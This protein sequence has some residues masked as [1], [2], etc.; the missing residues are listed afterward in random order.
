MATC[1]NISRLLN[2]FQVLNGLSRPTTRLWRYAPGKDAPHV[3]S[4]PGGR[5]YRFFDATTE[6]QFLHRML[7]EAVRTELPREL[8]WLSGFDAAFEQLNGE[9]NLPRQTCRAHPHGA[10][11]QRKAVVEQ[12]QEVPASTR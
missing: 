8:Y 4:S 5:P 7:I 9:L 3:I 1:E 10:I 6:V 12:A 2:A 11:E